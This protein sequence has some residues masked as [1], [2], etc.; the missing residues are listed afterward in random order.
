M[1]EFSRPFLNRLILRRKPAFD[2]RFREFISGE[3]GI[4]QT[5]EEG[6]TLL[7][8]ALLENRLDQLEDLIGY[9]HSVSVANRWG[10]TPIDLAYFLG[11]K[12]FLPLLR[13]YKEEES[14]SVYR[15]SDQKIHEI[16]LKDF[17]KKLEIECIEH[18]EFEHPDYLRWV[19]AKCQRQLRRQNT[20]KMNRWTLA[21]HQKGILNPRSDHIYIRYIDHRMGYGVFAKKD[22]P[23]LTYIGEYTGVVTRRHPKKTRLND[24]VFGYLAGPKN[25]PFIIDARK[26]GN[27]TRFINHSESPN[28]NSRWVIVKGVTRIIV[29]TNA[30]IPKGTQLTY[31]YGKY[32]WR[33]RAA[34]A[35]I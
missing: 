35:L 29:F 10:M 5:D 25:T 24:Y 20:R 14:M 28:M 15:N 23:A 33:S 16:P 19:V 22:L 13:P 30:F 6:N 21:L 12:D 9:G 1:V 4:H 3:K 11:R 7:H 27:F 31:D 2:T 26:K 34:P 32:Y 17:E 8:I 18:L